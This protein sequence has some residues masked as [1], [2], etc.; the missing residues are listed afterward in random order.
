M[1]D[2]KVGGRPTAEQ[3]ID[4]AIRDAAIMERVLAGEETYTAIARSVGLSMAQ[5]GKIVGREMGKV[6]A[7][8]AEQIRAQE[9]V[10]LLANRE[11]LDEVMETTHYVVH[12]GQLTNIVDHGPLIAAIAQDGAL[13]DRI[14]KLYGADMPVKVDHTVSV[15]FSVN[16]V[17]LGALQ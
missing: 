17:P 12:A 7:A 8:T 4:V 2:S 13:S 10:R 1:I 3:S 5:V 16:G 6:K 15:A 14:R 9:H 11:R